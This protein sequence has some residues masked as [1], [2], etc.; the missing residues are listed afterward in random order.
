ML[1]DGNILNGI[2]MRGGKNIGFLR[3]GGLLELLRC[4]DIIY[5]GL[6]D[7]ISIL[8]DYNKVCVVENLFI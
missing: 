3:K 2:E 6:E 1:C 8:I 7:E 5:F 4:F